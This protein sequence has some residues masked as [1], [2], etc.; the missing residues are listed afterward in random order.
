MSVE[1]PPEEYF[2]I[3]ADGVPLRGSIQGT[4]V[5]QQRPLLL[6]NG[7]SSGIDHWG[8][9]RSKLGRQTI[10]F[11]YPHAEHLKGT[12]TVRQYAEVLNNGIDELGYEDVDVL[13]H[14]FGGMVG[15]EYAFRYGHRVGRLVLSGTMP[16]VTSVKPGSSAWMLRNW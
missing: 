9:L 8:S 1:Y 6:F 16:G 7:L 15:Q 11:D 13:G 10:A 3:E 4:A 12:P 2:T 5:D 14:S